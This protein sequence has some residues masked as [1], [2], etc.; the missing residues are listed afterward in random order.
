[1]VNGITFSEQ[2]ITSA[3]FAHFMYIFLNHANGITKGCDISYEDGNVYIQKGYFM[4]YGRMV[5]I[6]GTEELASPDV[7]S[8]QLYCTVVFEIDLSKTNTVEEFKQGYFR[9][10]SSAEG[11]PELIQEDLDNGGL[12]YQMPWCQYIKTIEGIGEFR[13]I[14]EILD[15]ESVWSAVA[16][17]N[18][19][20][21]AEFDG[22]FESQKQ[23]VEEMIQ[24]LEEQ[25]YVP[26]VT[27]RGVK[28]VEVLTDRWSAEAPYQQT[29]A[30]DG[31]LEVDT[32]VIKEYIPLGTTAEEEKAIKKA[33]GMISYIDTGN[34]EI[35]VTCIGKKPE[36]DFQ[37]AI[38]GV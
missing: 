1:M 14:R 10:L 16:N 13:D 7:V 8:G 21:K 24:E 25:G 26:L 15:M 33:A 34:G 23:V 31:V 12:I 11:Y 4:E 35:T 19:K 38:K 17:Q 28:Y 6:V 27:E 5:Q 20:Y 18:A 32:P 2:L 36:R 37:L 29:I 30:V 22:Y 3:N 9:T